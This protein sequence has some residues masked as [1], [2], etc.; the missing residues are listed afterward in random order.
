MSDEQVAEWVML[1]Q[2]FPEQL[3]GLIKEAAVEAEAAEGKQQK[4][5]KNQQAV[6]FIRDFYQQAKA[7]PEC[8][9]FKPDQ[10]PSSP[11]NARVIRYH[12]TRV[13]Q[14]PVATTRLRKLMFAG[15]NTMAEI[16]ML[17]LCRNATDSLTAASIRIPLLKR[18]RP[19]I[20]R[21]FVEFVESRLFTM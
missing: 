2:S 9:I 19:V 16:E 21:C 4:K 14:D 5:K 12:L 11:D 7:P 3:R 8:A 1:W 20:A 17:A 10:Q 6:A 18:V 15:C 13:L